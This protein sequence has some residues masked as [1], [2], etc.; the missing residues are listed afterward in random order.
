M[1]DK[2]NEVTKQTEDKNARTTYYSRLGISLND[3]KNGDISTLPEVG[4][5]KIHNGLVCELL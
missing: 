5:A 1:S 2:E 4:I 3:L